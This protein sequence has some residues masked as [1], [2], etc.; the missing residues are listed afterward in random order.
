[1]IDRDIASLRSD[2]DSQQPY[3]IADD[4]WSPEAIAACL[5]PSTL[6]ARRRTAGGEED[7]RC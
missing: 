6:A 7:G 5:P 4:A 1:M 2:A 3:P